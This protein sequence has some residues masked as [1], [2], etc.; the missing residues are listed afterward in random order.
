MGM[1][2]S[3]SG[4]FGFE[5]YIVR[6]RAKLSRTELL[7][8]MTEED[9]LRASSKTQEAY[10]L[11]LNTYN[12]KDIQVAIKKRDDSS[13]ALSFNRDMDKV[14]EHLADITT[15]L[16][17]QAI[18]SFISEDKLIE[19]GIGEYLKTLRN[20]RFEYRND[21]EMN[22]ITVYQRFDKSQRGTHGV[23]DLA[24]NVSLYDGENKPIDLLSLANGK[25][26]VLICGSIS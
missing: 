2:H 24:P 11:A 5:P 13:Q 14:L 12:W 15:S 23:G 26:L 1:F 7:N 21:D 19:V 6:S 25:P 9:K 4:K 10:S 8:I 20:A 16:Q 22:N 18:R 3:T 17:E